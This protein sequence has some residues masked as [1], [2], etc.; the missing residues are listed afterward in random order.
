[1]TDKKGCIAVF[2]K[3]PGLSPL[4]TRLAKDIGT[5]EAEDIYRACVD[6]VQSTLVDFCKKN[7][8]WDVVWALGEEQGKDDGFWQQRPFHKVWTGDGGLGTRLCHVDTLLKK[9]YPH[10]ILIGTDCPH[11]PLE[12]FNKAVSALSKA[13]M[14]VGPSTDGGYYLFGS[15]DPIRSS[16]WQSVPYS[17]G[18]T[19]DVFLDLLGNKKT[20]AYLKKL[21]DLDD[22]SDA[23][24]IVGEA[25]HLK[26]DLNLRYVQK[27][28]S[29]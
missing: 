25:Q 29:L 3:T 24:L 13:S 19:L 4:K 27:L 12:F 1:M 18:N 6:A 8:D 15:S 14:I 26:Q 17:E 22:M 16:L 11:I 2:A 21:T 7:T 9:S 5:Y 10:V 23:N 20:I 28:K